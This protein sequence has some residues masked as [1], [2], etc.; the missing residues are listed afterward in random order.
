MLSVVRYQGTLWSLDNRRLCWVFRKAHVVTITVLLDPRFESHPRI[1]NLKSD[2]SLMA[3][4]SCESYFPRVRGKVR[5]YLDQQGLQLPAA[6]PRGF[7]RPENWPRLTPASTSLRSPA[8]AC[9]RASHTV[10]DIDERPRTPSSF[11]QVL[12][13][14]EFARQIVDSEQATDGGMLADR[15]QLPRTTRCFAD[16][17][18]EAMKE[19]QFQSTATPPAA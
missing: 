17:L 10:I 2:R 8:A 13:R 12:P 15:Q 5:Q 14:A 7:L 6:A 18:I 9:S 1:V 16:E 19:P 4:W 11:R 3:R